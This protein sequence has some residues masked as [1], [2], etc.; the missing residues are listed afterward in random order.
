MF[1]FYD[2]FY[3][4]RKC[5]GST[6]DTYKYLYFLIRGILSRR[7]ML[8]ILMYSKRGSLDGIKSLCRKKQHRSTEVCV[9][10]MW[11]P[12]PVT[13]L[14]KQWAWCCARLKLTEVKFQAGPK[15]LNCWTG[16]NLIYQYQH[17]GA[18]EPTRKSMA[19]GSSSNDSQTKMK[20]W[21]DSRV[22]KGRSVEVWSVSVRHQT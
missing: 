13:K 18:E 9:L 14:R 10:F 19:L 17:F 6:L 22:R 11:P 2:T 3:H 15:E 12:V 20:W 21:R 4:T 16:N 7:K 8:F 5:T 1:Y